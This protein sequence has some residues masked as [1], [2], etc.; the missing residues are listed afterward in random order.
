MNQISVVIISFNEERNIKRCIESV[1]QITDEI[2]VVDSFSTDNTTEIAK[3]LGANIIQ[4]PFTGH[5]E[6]KNFA[7]TCAS[8][9]YVLSLD[10]DEWLEEALVS[11]IK[12]LKNGVLADG[13]IFNRLNRYCGKWIRHGAWY[14]DKKLRLW[15]RNK[16]QWVGMNPHDQFEMQDNSQIVEVPLNILHESYR[17]VDEHIRKSEYFSTIAANAYHNAGK[18]SD[19]IKI[20]FSPVVRFIRDYF[21]KLGFLDGYFGL[22]IALQTAKEVR[23]KYLK[24]ALLQ[25]S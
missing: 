24:L 12:D 7:K 6:Q 19:G 2:I 21:L 20:Y 8:F 15:N 1:L 4:H 3:E 25:K 10:A 5:I 16:G 22:I 11:K 17:S 14:P 23:Q 18:R 13:Y 9:D